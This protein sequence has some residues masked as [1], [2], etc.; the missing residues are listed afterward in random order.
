M[1][2]G[3]QSQHYLDHVDLSDFVREYVQ[4]SNYT[5]FRCMLSQKS[6]T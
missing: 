2:S 6:F 3:I 1:A 5:D 4:I